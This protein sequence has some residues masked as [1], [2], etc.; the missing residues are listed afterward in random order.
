MDCEVTLA[1]FI[2][3]RRISKLIISFLS[4]VGVLWMMEL[5]IGLCVICGVNIGERWVFFVLF[6]V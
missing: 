5:N 4:L 2:K 6:E 1:V 3:I